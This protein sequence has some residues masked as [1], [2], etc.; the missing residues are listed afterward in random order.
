ML[1]ETS[2]CNGVTRYDDGQSLFVTEKKM[3]EA[4]SHGN[5]T[6]T[7]NTIFLWL[8]GNNDFQVVFHTGHLFPRVSFFTLYLIA[9][10][11][12]KVG[13]ILKNCIK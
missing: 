13:Q 5:I 12:K 9:T 4:F 2:N 6:A 3:Q 11:G 7:D 10:A 1:A 8:F